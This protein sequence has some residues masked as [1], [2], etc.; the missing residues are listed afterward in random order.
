[1]SLGSGRTLSFAAAES[2]LLLGL[3]TL[4]ALVLKGSLSG[5]AVTGF[6]GWETT[7]V[8]FGCFAVYW[9]MQVIGRNQAGFW[10][11]ALLV[12]LAQGPAIWTHNALEWPQFFGL[13]TDSENVRSLVR[14]TLWFLV[15]LVGLMS[16]YRTMGLRR[17]D[18]LLL[19]RQVSAD[20][21]NGVMFGEGLVLVGLMI[22]GAIIA[23]LM[24]LTS[25]SLGRNQG[26]LV[27]S[28]WSVMTVGASAAVLFV[29]ALFV[30]LTR[31]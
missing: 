29:F 31:P 9:A 7:G 1:M 24:V 22:C 23:F 15:S 28:P 16:L 21:R 3:L 10:V 14:D 5:E 13:E 19:A 18:D 8:I 30:W 25:S 12:V 6:G 11:M 20:D 27:L 26:I 2:V 4:A 17:L